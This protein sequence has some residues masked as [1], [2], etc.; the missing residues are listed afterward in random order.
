MQR[1]FHSASFL[2]LKNIFIFLRIEIYICKS[3][4]A[5]NVKVL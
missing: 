1:R 2:T 3:V 5:K 4:K